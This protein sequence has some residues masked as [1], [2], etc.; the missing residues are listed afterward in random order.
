M[1][2]VGLGHYSRTGKDTLANALVASLHERE[3][4]LRVKKLPMAWKM[5]QI[6]HD[7]YAWAG[8]REGEFYETPEGEPY[9]DI[10]LPVLGKTPV[11]VWVAIGTYAMRDQVH[12]DT[13]L[14][15]VFETDHDCDVL[16][17]PDVRFPNEH[18]KARYKGAKLVKVVRPGYGPRK[19]VAD[20]ALLGCVDW[21]VVAGGSGEMRELREWA[22]RIA[23]EIM[24]GRSF[25]QTIAEKR[26]ALKVEVIEPC[27]HDPATPYLG[28]DVVAA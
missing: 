16:V 8:L 2:I 3:P 19:T 27:E 21:D 5:K 24:G 23:C 4:K 13:W 12:P 6:A 1:Y 14:N 7:L 15:Y 26:E 10:V 11:E 18:A 17:V 28:Y 20:R 9:R 25:T 22:S